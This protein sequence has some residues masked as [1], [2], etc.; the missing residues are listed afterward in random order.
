MTKKKKKNKA[1]CLTRR[2]NPEFLIVMSRESVGRKEGTG[3]FSSGEKRKFCRVAETSLLRREKKKKESPLLRGERK[4][5][6]PSFGREARK[7]KKEKTWRH[8][9]PPRAKRREGSPFLVR[10]KG[11]RLQ[12]K[13]HLNKAISKK[14]RKDSA[15]CGNKKGRNM[16]TT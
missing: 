6:Q 2:K 15:L 14:K 11:K 1:C 9:P 16:G 5:F 10:K 4:W 8:P 13:S 7:G 3:G 12:K